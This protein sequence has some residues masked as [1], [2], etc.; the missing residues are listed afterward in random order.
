MSGSPFREILHQA[1]E[2]LWLAFERTKSVKHS[3][4][5]GSGRESALDLFLREQLPSRF[6]VA[7]GEAFDV[8]KQRSAQLDVVVYD[9]MG[10]K[11]LKIDNA[12]VLFPAEALLAVTEVKSVLTRAELAKALA[13]AGKIAQ[14][15]P[16]ERAF[17]VGRT[18]GLDAS[19]RN[20]R[21]LFTIFAFESDLG[22]D[23]WPANEWKRLR[24][25]ASEQ[26]ISEDK[27]SR[28]VVLNRGM[29]LPPDGVARKADA[30]DAPK[31]TLREWFL[32]LTNFLAREIARRDPLEWQLYEAEQP[33]Q[34][35]LKLEGYSRPRRSNKPLTPSAPDGGATLR[36]IPPRRRRR[37]GSLGRRRGRPDRGENPRT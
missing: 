31:G 7:R 15:R 23:D 21:C 36:A 10:V 22:M 11:P 33:H 27:V 28:L 16:Y 30:G 19:D 26:G 17:I 25:V 20:P 5:K 37:R 13:G 34:G 3:G 9:Q 2:E 18:G 14:L 24:E 6:G 8:G 35:W 1:Q 32:H 29:L 12:N 4:L